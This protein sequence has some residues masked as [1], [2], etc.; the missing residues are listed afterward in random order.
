MESRIKSPCPWLAL[1]ITVKNRHICLFKVLSHKSYKKK[2]FE[3]LGWNNVMLMPAT[4]TGA[5]RRFAGDGS[6]RFLRLWP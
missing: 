2:Y 3:G 6:R 5:Q 4:V 1:Q